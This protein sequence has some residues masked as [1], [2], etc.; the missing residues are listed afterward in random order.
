[1][2]SMRL[3]FPFLKKRLPLAAEEWFR[4]TC[5]LEV[6]PGEGIEKTVK[7]TPSFRFEISD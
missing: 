3:F 1:L 5:L 7:K 6:F 2:L 4:A